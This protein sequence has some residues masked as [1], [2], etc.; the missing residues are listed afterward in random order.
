L[1]FH[2]KKGHNE[3]FTLSSGTFCTFF[4]LLNSPL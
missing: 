3:N 4:I 2:T 1:Q